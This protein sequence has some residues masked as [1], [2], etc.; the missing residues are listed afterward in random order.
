MSQL[1]KDVVIAAFKETYTKVHNKTPDL[2]IKSGWYKVDGGKGIRLAQLQA[3]T[4]ELA[5]QAKPADAAP[6]QEKIVEETQVSVEAEVS[7]ETASEAEKL[8]TSSSVEKAPALEPEAT[9][10]PSESKPRFSL[11]ALWQQVIGKAKS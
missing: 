2:E 4:E 1:D 6:S 8:E 7:V 10:K 9:Q 11:K 3:L 5:V